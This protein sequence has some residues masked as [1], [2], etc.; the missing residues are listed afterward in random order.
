MQATC[1]PRRSVQVPSTNLI[2]LTKM[3]HV[4]DSLD[5]DPDASSV[6]AIGAALQQRKSSRKYRIRSA[7]DAVAEGCLSKRSKED[8]LNPGAYIA[9]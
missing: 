2:S 5:D 4:L 8:K 3:L 7:A 9:S 1:R 6:S